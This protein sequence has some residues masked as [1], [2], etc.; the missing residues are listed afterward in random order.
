MRIIIYG[1]LMIILIIIGYLAYTFFTTRA[2]SPGDTLVF[3]DDDFLLTIDYSRP[4]KK[5]RHIFG[6]KADEALV[7]YGEYWRT[8][9]NEATEIEFNKDILVEGK[10]LQS[11]RYRLY[12]IPDESEWIISF[13]SELGQWGY[14][15]PDY[16]LDILRVHVNPDSSDTFHEQFTIETN[17]HIDGKLELMFYWD[18]LVIPLKIAY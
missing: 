5:G 17:L 3:Q 11:G 6:A 13:N 9:A 4:F 8:G 18:K 12:T 10:S 7:P 1:I 14:F 15:E 16:S 2:S